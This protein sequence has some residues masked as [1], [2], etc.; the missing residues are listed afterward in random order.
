MNYIQCYRMF[1]YLFGYKLNS[2]I[3]QLKLSNIEFKKIITFKN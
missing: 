2:F 3:D 1:Y